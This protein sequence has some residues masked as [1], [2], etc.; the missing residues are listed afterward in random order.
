MP[1]RTLP[2]KKIRD[3]IRL[4]YEARLSHEQIARAL[5]VSNGVVAKYVARVE[6]R[7]FDPATLLGLPEEELGRLLAPAA[8]QPRHCS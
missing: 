6:A 8:R 5:A 7:S 3:L 2:M 1:T 4:K